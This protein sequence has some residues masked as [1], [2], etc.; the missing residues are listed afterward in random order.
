M[1]SFASLEVPS[2]T[3]V[4]DWLNPDFNTET[5]LCALKLISL[6]VIDKTGC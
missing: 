4:A 6:R 5:L 3:M 1:I 2:V